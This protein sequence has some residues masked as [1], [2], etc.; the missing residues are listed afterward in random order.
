LAQIRSFR[1]RLIPE[2]QAEFDAILQRLRLWARGTGVLKTNEEFVLGPS[3]IIKTKRSLVL[4]EVTSVSWFTQKMAAHFGIVVN[5]HLITSVQN[6]LHHEPALLTL[7]DVAGETRKGLLRRSHA[8]EYI[9]NFVQ[10]ML[11]HAGMELRK[12]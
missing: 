3:G 4:A 6:V 8:G 9:V 12:P 5:K 10:E 1:K 2:Q 7:G 11:A